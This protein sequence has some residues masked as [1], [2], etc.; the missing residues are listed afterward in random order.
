MAIKKTDPASLIICFVDDLMFVTRIA[1]T[2]NHLGYR[3]LSLD[4][5]MEPLVDHSNATSQP[6]GEPMVG[7]DA[8]LIT[9]LTY[10][11]PSL[12]IFDL[13]SVQVPWRRWIAIL[14]SSPATRRIP[15]L[16][17]GPH[18]DREN[19]GL[20]K[21]LSADGVVPRSKF[22]Q[23][24]PQLIEQYA[25]HHDSEAIAE[26]CTEPLSDLARE[27][28]VAFNKGHYFESHEYLEDAWNEEISPANE[29]Y[30]AILQIAV[31]YLQIERANYPG[32]IKMFL[33][34]RQWLSPLPDYCRG[35]NIAQ[36]GTDAD[37]AYQAL[38]ELGPDGLHRFEFEL[39]KP[40]LYQSAE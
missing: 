6:Q 36:L 18:V 31:A 27:G 30:R 3:L 14:K 33:R 15:I 8:S 28:I 37:N 32:A 35:I 12:I 13:G 1:S 40:V 34:A 2:V 20:A 23:A 22:A 21:D 29:L 4:D 10:L 24:M 11:Q 39:L 26:G 17:Y 7:P 38:L 25:H 16:C 19:L 9:K 5:L